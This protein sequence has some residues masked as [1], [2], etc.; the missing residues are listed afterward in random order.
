[1]GKEQ[2]EELTFN[3][4]VVRRDRE[5]LQQLADKIMSYKDVDDLLQNSGFDFSRLEE[6]HGKL[7]ARSGKVGEISEQRRIA[8]ERLRDVHAK[9]TSPPKVERE[10]GDT[11]RGESGVGRLALP[12]KNWPGIEGTD[13]KRN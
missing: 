2:G 12:P 10:P 7:A 8:I 4:L 3:G 1:M 5:T 11:Y 9:L 13:K 6:L